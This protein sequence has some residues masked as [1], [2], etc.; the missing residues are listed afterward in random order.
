[1]L[2]EPSGGTRLFLVRHGAVGMEGTLYGHLDIPLCPSGERQMEEAAEFLARE[3]LGAVYCSDL[4]RA[5]SGA[6]AIGRRHGLDPIERPA[7]REMDMGRWDGRRFSEIWEAERDLVE[8]WWRDLEGCAVP[9]G[10]SLAALRARVLPAL[11]ELLARHPGESVCL[12]AHGGVNRVL[13]FE[14]MGLPLARFQAVA[15]DYGCVNLVEYFPDGN[16]VVQMM[17]RRPFR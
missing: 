2:G 10:E 8:T 14:A 12:V 9:G 15:Q 16:A 3:P 1:M 6:V 13:L 4:G 17:N 7:F 5:R 11:D